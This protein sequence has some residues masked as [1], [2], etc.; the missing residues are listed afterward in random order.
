MHIA[1]AATSEISV[2]RIHSE[3]RVFSAGDDRAG[4]HSYRSKNFK[5]TDGGEQIVLAFFQGATGRVDR[6]FGF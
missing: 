3:R 5:F 2:F 4:G 6:S 1:V